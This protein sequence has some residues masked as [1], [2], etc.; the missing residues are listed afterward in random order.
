MLFVTLVLGMMC[1]YCASA[2]GPS[3]SVEEQFQR[4]HQKM[5]QM[6][7]E[8]KELKF[9]NAI[10]KSGKQNCS[11]ARLLLILVNRRTH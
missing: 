8:I 1:L 6:Q 11:V 5:D 2:A 4:I 7:M 10:P 9:A 3:G